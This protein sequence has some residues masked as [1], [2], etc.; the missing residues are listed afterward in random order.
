MSA[1]QP[2][3]KRLPVKPSE[4]HLRKQAKRR[5]KTLGVPLAEAQH[6]LARDYGATH[7]AELM[8]VVETMLR[9]SDQLAYA[10]YEMEALPKAANAN[11]LEKVRAI[12]ASGEFTQHD[13]DLALA[14]S[15]L[16]FNE[17]A[18]IARLLLE[19]GADPDGQYGS[20]YGPIIFVTGESLDVGGLQFLVDAGADVTFP[21]IDTKYGRH[22]P[23]SYWLGTY[24]RG[25]N[26][27]KQKGIEILL[28]HGA[29]VPPE[30][31]PELMAIHRGSA[32]LLCKLLDADRSQLRRTF[33]DMPYGN[34]LLRGATLLHAAVEFG[35]IDCI[36]AILSRY[37]AS[38]D[39]DMNSRAEVID[40]IG[41]QTPIFHAINTNNDGN[42]HVLEFLIQR[43]GQHIDMGIRATWHDSGTGPQTTPLTPLEYAE[44]AK[45][46]IDPKRAHFRPR[47]EDEIALLRPL[48]RRAAIRCKCEAG[49][50]DAVG[51]M[52]DEH[53][54]LLTPDLWPPTIFKAKSLEL[55]QLLLDRGLDPNQSGAP[56][57][58]LHLA[59]YQVLPEIVEL[60]IQRGANVNDLNPWTYWRS[61]PRSSAPRPT[62][63]SCGFA[64]H[65]EAP[66]LRTRNSTSRRSGDSKRLR[67]IPRISCST[68]PSPR[69][70]RRTSPADSIALRNCWHS[71]PTCLRRAFSSPRAW[72]MPMQSR[73]T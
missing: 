14:R 27:A 2:A 1:S 15:V 38:G 23:L 40:G 73:S 67:L 13:L 32:K 46:E 64:M 65:C 29:L 6:A 70:N 61:T 25:R 37:R 59:C 49:D 50:I 55:T 22:C 33:R 26:D 71:T 35:Q 45:R 9:G 18:A 57:R 56:R 51:T 39:L 24:V 19:H 54:D 58:P 10:T 17:R 60:L 47:V 44:K 30:V 41:G 21:P 66:A 48:D 34:I 4:E 42:F 20:D 11:D 62:R 63:A 3:R 28:K 53:P 68:P 16:R 72:G 69:Q 36:D 5:A 52:L 8:H 12:L 7:W 43:V 31:T